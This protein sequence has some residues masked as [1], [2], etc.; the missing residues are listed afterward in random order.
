[1]LLDQYKGNVSSVFRHIETTRQEHE[2]AKRLEAAVTVLIA[3]GF[4]HSRSEL[5]YFVEAYGGDVGAVR[6]HLKAHEQAASTPPK[7]DYSAQVAS[8]EAKGY[9]LDTERLQGLLEAFEGNVAEVEKVLGEIAVRRETARR[10]DAAAPGVCTCLGARSGYH[11]Q[12]CPG[13]PQS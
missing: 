3:E 2:A 10:P 8:L 7:K 11:R 1:M 9:Q 5:R 6:A 12:G 13:A 4:K